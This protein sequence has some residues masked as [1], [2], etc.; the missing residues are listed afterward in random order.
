MPVNF[1]MPRQ[2]DAEKG[3]DHT[4]E[5]NAAVEIAQAFQD[6]YGDSE[7][8]YALIFNADDP[9]ADLVVLTNFGVGVAD[10][11]HITGTVR[12]T[13][14]SAWSIYRG[15]ERRPLEVSRKYTNPFQQVRTYRFDFYKKMLNFAQRNASKMPDWM[16]V[17]SNFH[18]QA[19]IIFTDE[20]KIELDLDPDRTKPWFEAIQL[21]R[22]PQWAYTLAFTSSGKRDPLNADQMYIL[23]TDLLGAEPWTE[24]AGLVDGSE[25]YG[26]LQ[27]FDDD[28]NPTVN[29]PLSSMNTDLGREPTNDIRLGASGVSRHHARITREHNFIHITDLNSTN[30]TWVN[31]KKLEPDR[32]YKLQDGDM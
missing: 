12:G 11:K 20:A 22:A 14:D 21:A 29:H 18:L 31:G 1:Y 4:F 15:E 23:S 13:V 28:G 30:G 7:N 24:I 3:F 6:A 8:D 19:A 10:F 2:G 27:L 5:R 26:Y 9:P 25:V 16:A 17:R 32:P